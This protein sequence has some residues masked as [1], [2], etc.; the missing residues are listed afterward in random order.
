MTINAL[1]AA[2]VAE[3]TEGGIAQPLTAPVSVYAV[4]HD[5]A[6]LVGELPPPEVAALVDG[7]APHPRPVGPAKWLARDRDPDTA[8]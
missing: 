4:W 5:L 2:Y 8:A 1:M 7:P 3:L 6:A